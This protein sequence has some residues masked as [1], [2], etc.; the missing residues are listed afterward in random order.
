MI[1]FRKYNLA[2]ILKKRLRIEEKNVNQYLFTEMSE[3]AQLRLMVM[4]LFP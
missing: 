4:Q 3:T 1:R 2:K